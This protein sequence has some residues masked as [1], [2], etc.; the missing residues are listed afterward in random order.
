MKRVAQV[1]GLRQ[2]RIAEYREL[3]RNVPRPVLDRLRACHI[4][5]YSIHLLGHTLFAYFEYHGEDLEADLAALADDPATRA[6]WTR[7][8]P[9]QRPVEHAG[10]GQWWAS[11]EQVFLME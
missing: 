11:T 9:C 4:A 3:H 1:I 8:D 2:D 10:P 6:W 5:N 7:T